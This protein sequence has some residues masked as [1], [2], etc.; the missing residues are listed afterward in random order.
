MR[1]LIRQLSAASFAEEPAQPGL[2][3]RL[4]ALAERAEDEWGLHVHLTVERLD[5]PVPALLREQ[6]YHMVH[7]ALV[8]VWR[9]ANASAASVDLCTHDHRVEISIAD[10]GRGFPFQGCYELDTLNEM[11]IGPKTLKERVA[12]LGGTLVIDSNDRGARL[13][14]RLPLSAVD[15]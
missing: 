11:G 12:A 15:A 6:I 9:H 4:R 14:I 13:A 3:A 5:T 2:V 10:D 8:N 1:S 7:E